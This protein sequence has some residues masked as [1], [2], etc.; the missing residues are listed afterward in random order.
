M[1]Q[2]VTLAFTPQL[3][4]TANSFCR[5]KVVILA[6]ALHLFCGGK[7]ANQHVGDSGEASSWLRG[8]VSKFQAEREASCVSS[9]FWEGGCPPGVKPPSC[10]HNTLQQMNGKKRL[11]FFFCISLSHNLCIDLHICTPSY[12]YFFFTLGPFKCPIFCTIHWT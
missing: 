3:P 12:F 6:F 4:P 8:Y 10:S 9:Y 5:S 7:N 11:L 1:S 2:H